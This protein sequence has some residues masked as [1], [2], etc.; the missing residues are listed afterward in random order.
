[1]DYI[2]KF[3][4]KDRKQ[5]E[6]FIE[7]SNNGTLFHYRRFL[8]Y[9]DSDRFVDHSLLFY[10]REKLS[11]VLTGVESEQNG[12]KIYFSH[13]GASYGGF[14][15][16][17]STFARCNQWVENFDRYLI[18]NNFKKV[19]IVQPPRIYG[20]FEDETLEY[21]LLW[22]NFHVSENYISSIIP[23]DGD[24]TQ[25]LQKVYKRKNRSGKYYSNLV[26]NS[27]LKFKWENDFEKFYPIL[28]ENKARFNAKPTHSLEEL[29]KLDSLMPGCLKLLLLL[30]DGVPIGGTLNF[31]ANDKLVIIFYNMINYDYLDLQSAT[32]QVIETIRWAS[33]NGYQYLD[34]GVSQD[35]QAE[36]PLT[37]QPSL[38]RFKEEFGAVGHVRKVFQKIYK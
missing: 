29:I 6:A 21:A 8:D 5:W 17:T 23:L 4:Q 16:H 13:P 35:P 26:I 38:I 27:G 9:H 2:K 20:F 12:E 36:N 24:K 11:A 14:V 32:L 3:E 7:Q 30:K 31:I 10:T 25:L 33:S 19:I 15:F 18:D 22:N 37:P 28:L 34:F 1:M